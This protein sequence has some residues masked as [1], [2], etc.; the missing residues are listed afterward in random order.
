M[1]K[2]RAHTSMAV[3]KNRHVFIF[4]GIQ[5]VNFNSL[6][7][8]HAIE[9][10]DL[11]TSIDAY[12]LQMARWINVPVK[13]TDFFNCEPRACAVLSTGNDIVIFGGSKK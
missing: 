7:A 2:M 4:N 1:E 11:G 6:S 3:I 8:S 13:D 5:N 9:Y 10:I 12:S